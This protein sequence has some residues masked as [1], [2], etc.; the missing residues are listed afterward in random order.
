MNNA[1]YTIDEI[2]EIITPLATKHGLNKVYVFGSYA[3]GNA[4]GGSDIDL[5]ID[6]SS[7][8][9]LFSLGS[10]YVDFEEALGKNLDIVT[11]NSLKFNKDKEFISNLEKDRVLIYEC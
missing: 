8:E 9:G 11:L 3:K 5:C 10:V 7:I 4:D 6:A 2:K 1:V